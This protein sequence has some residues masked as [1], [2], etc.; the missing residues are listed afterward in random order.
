MSK[1]IEEQ[2]NKIR[3]GEIIRR[4]HPIYKVDETIDS[5]V[6]KKILEIKKLSWWKRLLN[7]F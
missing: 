3:E 6:D 5:A 1:E 7:K 4:T 2:L